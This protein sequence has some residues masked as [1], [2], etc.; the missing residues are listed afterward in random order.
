MDSLERMIWAGSK[1]WQDLES[2]YSVLPGF[3][4]DKYCSTTVVVFVGLHVSLKSS[5]RTTVRLPHMEYRLFQYE[6]FL[7]NTLSI[8]LWHHDDFIKSGNFLYLL[9]LHFAE[10]KKAKRHYECNAF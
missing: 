9:L 3:K 7:N 1:I 10:F 4:R 6:I 2:H 8:A 5:C